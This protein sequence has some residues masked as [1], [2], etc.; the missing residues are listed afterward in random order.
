MRREFLE[1]PDLMRVKFEFTQDD[2]IDATNRCSK[3]LKVV[4]S[5]QWT[6]MLATAVLAWALVFLFFYNA[7]VKGL[8]VGFVAAAIS[9]ALFPI[10]NKR[11][12]DKR[13][14]QISREVFGDANS[15]LCEVELKPEGVWV[16]QMSRQV[17]HEW[18]SVVEIKE[19]PDSVDIF[20]RD[21]LGVIVRN[22]AFATPDERS[23][24]IELAKSSLHLSKAEVSPH[25]VGD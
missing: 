12:I 21:G 7:P 18:P 2:L 15:F 4:R 13:I 14:R 9:A 11:A 8:I 16:R 6:N 5:F 17:L 3:R 23:R 19:T 20:T 22:R 10:F 24:F 25:S 1:S